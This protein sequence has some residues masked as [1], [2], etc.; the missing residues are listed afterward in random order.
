MKYL[1]NN[2]MHILSSRWHRPESIS[3]MT[4]VVITAL[5]ISSTAYASEMSPTDNAPRECSVGIVPQ[6]EQRRLFTVWRPIMEKLSASTH[7]T[8]TLIGSSNISEF[9]EVFLNGGYDFVYFNPYHAVMAYK[10][11]G[12]VPLVRSGAKKLKGILVVP[13]D[14]PI[15]DV[16]KLDGQTLAFPSPNALGASLMMRAEL[17]TDHGL[18]ITP[19]YVKTHSSTYL[20]VAKGLNA[21]G[22]GVMRTFK[23]QPDHIRERLRVL[24]TTKEVYAHPFAVHPRIPEALQQQVQQAWLAL[25]KEEPALF[26]A[27]PMQNSVA[28]SLK[29]YKPLMD[30]GL[31]AFVGK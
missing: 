26:D 29:D 21:A 17:A 14:S 27:I 30:M 4:W 5:L 2:T 1:I 3:G 20:H 11:Q 15:M 12:Y 28:T 9:E 7:C 6:F 31:E 22:G 13:K 25:A 8:F 16:A 10:A 18:N 23:E 24:Y 19:L